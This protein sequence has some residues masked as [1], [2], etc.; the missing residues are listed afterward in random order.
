MVWVSRR[1]GECSLGIEKGGYQGTNVC[2]CGGGGTQTVCWFKP[3]YTC[4]VFL[5]CYCARDLYVYFCAKA[6]G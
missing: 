4:L 3:C 2:V 5:H 1:R 6:P